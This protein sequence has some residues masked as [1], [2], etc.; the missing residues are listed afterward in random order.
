MRVQRYRGVPDAGSQPHA[1]GDVVLND[2]EILALLVLVPDNDMAV[3]MADVEMADR[4]PM[5]LGSKV[6]RH[7]AHDVAGEA[8]KIRKL[9]TVFGRDDEVELMA[10]LP[11]ALHKLTSVRRVGLSP[12][13][14]SAF[15]FPGRS[16]AL[17]VTEMSVRSLARPFQPDNPRLHHHAAHSLA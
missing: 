4:D 2:N 3:W 6:L 10:V 12:I 5:E 17:Q 7:L 1:I 16:I 9:V 13:Q 14:P 11:P 15:S 8:A